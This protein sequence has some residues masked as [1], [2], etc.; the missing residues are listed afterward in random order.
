M[1]SGARPPAGHFNILYFAGA[2]TLI[3][4]ESE[5]LPAPLALGQLFSQLESGYPSLRSKI[6]D[7]CLVTANLEYVDILALA[8]FLASS[9]APSASSLASSAAS[10]TRLDLADDIARLILDV[11]HFV[12]RLACEFLGSP[13][14]I[15]TMTSH[16]SLPGHPKF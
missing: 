11:T 16:S 15:L 7:S 2:S 1:V 8:V 14:A 9:V 12:A 6:L 3:G 10:W 13:S 4:K 5:A